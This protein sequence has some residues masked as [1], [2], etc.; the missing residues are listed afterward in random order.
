LNHIPD[1]HARKI[2]A[3]E[4]SSRNKIIPTGGN[5]KEIAMSELTLQAI[6]TVEERLR[7][8]LAVIAKKK[9]AF[10]QILGSGELVKLF[11]F[12]QE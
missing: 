5:D 2:V 3:T 7:G 12:C 6:V 4:V 1:V 10:R 8:W 11:E 9:S